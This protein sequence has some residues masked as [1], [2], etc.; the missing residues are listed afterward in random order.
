MEPPLLAATAAIP[1]VPTVPC[2]VGFLPAPVWRICPGDR[3]GTTSR[4][5]D[6]YLGGTTARFAREGPVQ[7][8][9]ARSAQLSPSYTV[10]LAREARTGLQ[11]L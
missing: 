7:D 5:R 11:C 6:L 8:T 4:A 3:R 2:S 1:Q 10:P 9:R